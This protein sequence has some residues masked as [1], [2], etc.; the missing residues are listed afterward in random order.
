LINAP[1]QPTKETET[2]DWLTFFW[3]NILF[4]NKFSTLKR[5]KEKMHITNNKQL[6]PCQHIVEYLNI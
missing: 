4:Y 2:N 6:K 3:G 1:L 5:I